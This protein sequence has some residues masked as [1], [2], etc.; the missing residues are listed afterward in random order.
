[1]KRSILVGLFVLCSLFSK[2]QSDTVYLK[3]NFTYE[4]DSLQLNKYYSLNS[5]DSVEISSLKFYLSNIVLL[6]DHEAIWKEANSF[7]L[8]DAEVKGSTQ[9]ELIVKSGVR[10]DELSFNLGIDSLTNVSGVMG[11]DLDPSNNMYWTWQSGYINFKLEGRSNVCL[12]RKNEFKFHL[13]GYQFPYNSLQRVDVS[14]LQ[15]ASIELQLD[16]KEIIDELE[17]GEL[18]HIM[19]PSASAVKMSSDISNKFR[20]RLP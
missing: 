7:H 8:I 5:N 20:L 6:R 9:L 11:A 12:T 3:F 2:A 18:N 4:S 15:D 19:S 16:L 13:G 14:T 17:L 10:Y 1:M